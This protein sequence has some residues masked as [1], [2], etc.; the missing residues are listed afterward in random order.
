MAEA[1]NYEPAQEAPAA[2]LADIIVN[3]CDIISSIKDDI[4]E[5]TNLSCFVSTLM[6]IDTDLE[7]WTR[8][9]PADYDYTTVTSPSGM[10]DAE[11]FMR[12]YDTYSNMEI[13]N[14]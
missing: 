10:A 13:T 2:R 11:A 9:L 14:T 6:S 7:N 4:T 1:R 3:A 12:H 8:T 5:K